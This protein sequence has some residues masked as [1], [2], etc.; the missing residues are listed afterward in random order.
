MTD[1]KSLV[2]DVPFHPDPVYRPPSKPI[3]PVMSNQQRSQSSPG[4][5]DINP[6]INL[7]FKE[8]SP[9]Q[10]AV[11]SKTFQRPDKSFFQEP[12]ELGNLI[13]KGY[14]IQKFLP[15]QADIDK[16]LKVVQRKVLKGTHL[17]VDIKKI[18]V[19]YLQSSYFKDMY[20]SQNRL[21]SSKATIRKTETL[22]E[23]YILLDSLLLKTNPEKEAAILAISET[24]ADK[25]TAL[26]HSSLFA[27]H[28]GDI[29]TYLTMSDKFFIPHLIP[30]LRSYIKGCHLCQLACNEKPP[31]RQLQTRI[32]PNYTPLS[33]LCMDLKVMPRSHKGYKYIL[34]L[35]DKAT[36]Y[37]ITVPIHQ[38]RS[39]EIGEAL[40]DNVITKYCTPE[41]I[42]MGQ[43]STFM[44]SLMTY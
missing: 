34:C 40:I 24:C 26:Y 13:N 23:W 41:Y 27:G 15:K 12:K 8:S 14:L 39:D 3:R 1:N 19:G 29:K 17:P 43:D 20:L 4:I 28:Q 16:I 42:I 38:A 37:L 5:E 10:E 18:Q 25:I 33:R 32:N 2:P 44:S 6:N 7:D 9:F 36:N 22:A 11:L 21:P 31:P 30:Y 35:I